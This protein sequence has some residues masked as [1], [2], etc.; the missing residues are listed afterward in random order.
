MPATWQPQAWINY[1]ALYL[2]AIESTEALAELVSLAEA[3]G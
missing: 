2:S 3:R 1:W